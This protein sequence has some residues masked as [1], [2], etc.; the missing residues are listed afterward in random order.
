MPSE[1]LLCKRPAFEDRKFN[2]KISIKSIILNFITSKP[3][4][5]TCVLEVAGHL[6]VFVDT[7]AKNE[8]YGS[9]EMSGQIQD[10]GRIF[11][12][13]QEIKQNN[14]EAKQSN[15]ANEHGG[16]KESFSS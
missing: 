15:C 7:L 5:R 13:K 9:Y 8:S 12:R 11:R 16:Q 14:L 2:V 6:W 4:K 3:F 10:R 1:P